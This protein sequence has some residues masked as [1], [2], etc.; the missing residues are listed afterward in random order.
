MIMQYVAVDE[1]QKCNVSREHLA[2]TVVVQIHDE[3]FRGSFSLL[4]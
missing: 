4:G 2:F 1:I 3:L